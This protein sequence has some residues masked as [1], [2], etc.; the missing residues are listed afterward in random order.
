MSE[1]RARDGNG[2]KAFGRGAGW[3]KDYDNPGGGG[4][5]IAIAGGPL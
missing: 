4:G 2:Q 5:N 3:R 1:F